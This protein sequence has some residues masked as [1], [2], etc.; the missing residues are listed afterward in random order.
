MLITGFCL[1]IHQLGRILLVGLGNS[2]FH[3]TAGAEVL[4][5]SQNKMWPLGVFVSTGAVGLTLGSQYPNNLYV[6]SFFIGL[7][8]LVF[9]GLIFLEKNKAVTITNN[10]SPP[11]IP[12]WIPI[13]LLFCITI[14]SFMGFAKPTPFINVAFLPIIISIFVFGGK[15][16][17]GFLCDKWGIKRVILCSVPLACFLYFC[18]P[19]H[20]VI[21]GMAQFLINISMPITLFL[22]YRCMPNRTG[23]SFGL[24]A[25]FLSQAFLL[26]CFKSRYLILFSELFLLSI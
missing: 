2:L 18:G 24:A 12:I 23:F 26:P 6:H 13:G 9:I 15:F 10:I 22:L 16:I 11:R 5:T 4:E 20:Y 25:P 14:R 8:L 1:P 7:L 21:W 3:V 19:L 17:G